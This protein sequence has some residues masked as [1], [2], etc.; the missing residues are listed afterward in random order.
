MRNI[1]LLLLVMFIAAVS[2]FAGEVGCPVGPVDYSYCKGHNF[3]EGNAYPYIEDIQ[4]SG[5]VVGTTEVTV[6]TTCQTLPGD[7]TTDPTRRELRSTGTFNALL[8]AFLRID[9]V[10][11]AAPGARFN[12]R[13]LIDGVEVGGA[14]RFIRMK[15]ESTAALLPQGDDF[16]ATAHGIIAGNH[17]FEVKARM[18]DGGTMRVGLAWLTAQGSPIAYPSGRSVL[19]GAVNITGTWAPITD[20]LRFTVPAG[21]T[22]DIFPQAYFQYRGGTPGDHLSVGFG[23]KRRTDTQYAPSIRNSELAVN[24]PL[25]D[26]N[27]ACFWPTVD[28]ARDGINISDH[29]FGIGPGDWDLVLYAVNRNMRTTTVAYRQIELIAFPASAGAR[30]HLLKSP[31]G[32][33]VNQEFLSAP[34]LVSSTT[35]GPQPLYAETEVCGPWTKLAVMDVPASPVGVDENWVGEGYLEIVGRAGGD[36]T[37]PDIEMLVEASGQNT[38]VDFGLQT[39]SIGNGRQAVFF[40]IEAGRWGNT[41]A[42]PVDGIGNTLTLWARKRVEADGNPNPANNA[43]TCAFTQGQFVRTGTRR[44][45]SFTVGKRYMA[46]KLVPLG[47]CFH[48]NP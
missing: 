5:V 26:A 8:R 19:D 22:Y 27:G 23:L 44:D 4:T 45:A 6:M 14:T 38:P 29:L 40:F 33:L 34:V 48:F 36:W 1:F 15:P 39:L 47:T 11:G 41:D 16:N 20:T 28:S 17:L 43:P 24:C 12:V 32:T 35:T 7:P 42:T 25:K 46:V 3:S 2:A 18:V 37:E 21:Q 10:S 13:F 31:D 30:A 9:A